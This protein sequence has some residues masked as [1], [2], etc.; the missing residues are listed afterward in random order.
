MEILSAVL[1]VLV[2]VAILFEIA[3]RIGVPFPSL[4]VLG[5]VVLG[6]V[7]G[8]PRIQLEPELVLLVFLPPLLFTA[9][10]DTPIRELRRNLAP[11]LRLSI[12]LVVFTMVLVAIV[13]NALIPGLGWGAAFTLGA[14]VAPTD[15]LAATTVFRRLHTPRVVTTLVEG[16]ALLNDATALVAYRVAVAAVVGGTFVLSD[17]LR[18]FA[19]AAVAGVAIGYLVGRLAAE[20]LRRLDDPP[21]EVL[22]GLVAPFAAYLPADRLGLSGVLAAVAAGLVIGG[23]LGTILTAGS[24]V[25]WL[26]TWKMVGF[27]LNGFVFVLIGLELPEILEGLGG[28]EPAD[29]VLVIVAICAVV[30]A[31]RFVWVF[32]SSLLP[33]SPRQVVA[34]QDPRLAARLTVV[35]SWAG[36]RG[37]VSLAAALALPADFPER[38]LILLLT[39]SVILVTL[40]GQGLTL[41]AI[42][43]WA[44][45]H[46]AGLDGDEA[47]A[48]RAAAY[49]AGLAE[50]ERARQAW[51]SHQPLFE[52]LESSLRD[53]TQHLATDDPDETEERRQERLE[54]EEI[55]RGVIAAQRAAVIELRDRREINDATL[56]TIERELDLEELRMEG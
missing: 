49:E 27:V 56:R 15:A 14:I 45:G 26:T 23:R 22:V 38:N 21:V 5:G 42:V 19:I 17:A 10:V 48:A 16:E 46:A 39:F 13:A 31:A 33:G 43:R 28:R 55:Q 36:L 4:F 32:L 20:I 35:V 11:L 37:A 30:V 8:L 34:R 52:R 51:P 18:G 6:L 41:P 7:P 44:G 24:R 1:I 25:L 29:I 9:A 12:G 40:V 54:H 50:V 53:R 47:T 2:A 3:R